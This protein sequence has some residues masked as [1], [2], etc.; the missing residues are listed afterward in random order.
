ML[1]R[2][3][4]NGPRENERAGSPFFR[5]VP[6]ERDCREDRAS[7]IDSRSIFL[8]KNDSFFDHVLLAVTLF[9]YSV[10]ELTV[11]VT[12]PLLLVMINLINY[13]TPLFV[14]VNELPILILARTGK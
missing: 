14:Y 5:A 7:T 2:F 13:A 1:L 12:A 3:K 6:S 4:A 11:F 9:Y 10:D 8:S